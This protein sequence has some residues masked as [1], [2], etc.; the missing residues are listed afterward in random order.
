MEISLQLQAAFTFIVP[1]DFYHSNIRTHVRLLGPCFKTDCM[2]SYDHQQPCH[3]V[4]TLPLSNML[5]IKCATCS[6]SWSKTKWEG[7]GQSKRACAVTSLLDLKLY[8]TSYNTSRSQLPSCGA[9]HLVPTCVDAHCWE[10]RQFWSEDMH[11]W[12]I[13]IH[14]IQVTKQNCV[15]LSNAFL[16]TCASFSLVSRTINFLFK[17]LFIF[18]SWY[19]FAIGLVSILSFRRSLPPKQPDS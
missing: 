7:R 3:S 18:S 17:E 12:S 4:C 16:I 6:P 8:T 15:N 1:A 2:K 11:R 5:Q 9:N 19:L 10:M 14:R 13:W